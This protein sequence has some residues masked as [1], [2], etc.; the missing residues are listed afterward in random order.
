[1][2]ADL[3]QFEFE[4]ICL[5]CIAGGLENARRRRVA[6]GATVGVTFVAVARVRL[7]G[8]TEYLPNGRRKPNR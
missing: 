8:A 4:G 6:Q 5:E 7:E 1:M 2:S 3:A